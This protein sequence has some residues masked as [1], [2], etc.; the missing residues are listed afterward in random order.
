MCKVL[1]WGAAVREGISGMASVQG[2]TGQGSSSARG[3]SEA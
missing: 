1:Q 3:I 2:P